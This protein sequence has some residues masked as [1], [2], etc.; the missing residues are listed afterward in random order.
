MSPFVAF[1]QP[2]LNGYRT[3]LSTG[4]T[5]SALWCIHNYIGFG[6]LSGR[7]LSMLDNDCDIYIKH[8]ME[9][10]HTKVAKYTLMEKQI[11]V[12]LR[13][14]VSEDFDPIQGLADEDYNDE[15]LMF[16]AL[17]VYQNRLY[18]LLGDYER[19]AELAIERG[20][21]F[22]KNFTGNY[23]QAGDAFYR[24]IAF[25]EM[26]RKKKWNQRKYKQLAKREHTVIKAWAKKGNPNTVHCERILDAESAAIRGRDNDAKKLYQEG[27]VMATRSGFV[28]DAALACERFADYLMDEL[29]DREAAMFRYKESIRFWSD[30]GALRKVRM[31][32]DKYTALCPRPDEVLVVMRDDEG[33]NSSGGI[34]K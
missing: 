10:E 9:L 26:A 4:D 32:H 31:L 2:F 18:V 5:E 16:G 13:D 29:N 15:P 14:D 28:Q 23:L 6:L 21:T 33:S 25:Y 17:K 7:N 30:W 12:N 24:G 11:V 34:S 19:G 20:E 8:I 3:G 22:R 1:L 27:I